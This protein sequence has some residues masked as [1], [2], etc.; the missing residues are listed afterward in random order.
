MNDPTPTRPGRRRPLLQRLDAAVEDLNA[1]LRVL[2]IGLA[3]LDFTC[4]FAL[5]VRNAMP[6]RIPAEATVAT[7]ATAVIPADQ[8]AAPK[9]AN[10]E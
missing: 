7:P 5:E 8:A 1:M 9:A 6:P 4:F 3:I 2:A 10:G